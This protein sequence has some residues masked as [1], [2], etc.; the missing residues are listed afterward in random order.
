MKTL[1]LVVL[2]L[3]AVAL[4]APGLG[5]HD[6]PALVHWGL[7]LTAEASWGTTGF[8]IGAASD[9]A[10]GF[11]LAYDDP[12]TPAPPGGQ[13]LSAYALVQFAPVSFDKMN[14]SVIQQ[15]DDLMIWRSEFAYAK[16]FADPVPVAVSWDPTQLAPVPDGP[17]GPLEIALLGGGERTDMRTNSAAEVLVS[18]AQATTRFTIA[19]SATPLRAN[20]EAFSAAAGE[21]YRVVDGLPE[22]E[23]YGLHALTVSFREDCDDCSLQIGTASLGEDDPETPAGFNSLGVFS[24]EAVAA[25]GSSASGAVGGGT[26]DFLVPNGATDGEPD[27]IVLLR[28]DGSWTTV[29]VQ[30]LSEPEDDPLLYRATLP[31]LS[32]W[33]IGTQD[34]STGTAGGPGGGGAPGGSDP[35][36]D[37]EDPDEPEPNPPSDPPARDDDPFLPF[38]GGG[39]GSPWPIIAIVSALVVALAASGYFALRSPDRRV[40]LADWISERLKGKGPK[41]PE[42]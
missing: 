6:D 4:A 33:S 10:A 18:G 3:V 2:V 31:G 26:L 34:P 24:M 1:R 19:A 40:R 41:E 13:F 30:R 11:D 12:E 28:L 14:R 9:A 39:A 8:G 17:D 27:G 32:L 36:D 29:P 21:T 35:G 5:V 42:S 38:V 16:P 22:E 23:G 15:D 20:G 25:D 7:D 37:P